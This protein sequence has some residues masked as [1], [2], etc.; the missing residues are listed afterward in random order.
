MNS[1]QLSMHSDSQG[2]IAYMGLIRY[3]GA[4]STWNMSLFI[5]AN[6]Q[7]LIKDHKLNLDLPLMF[8][9]TSF[10]EQQSK[11]KAFWLNANN[12]MHYCLG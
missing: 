10:A 1:L 9:R 8:V 3:V 6:I 11:F 12:A 5:I 2:A 4:L 7:Y